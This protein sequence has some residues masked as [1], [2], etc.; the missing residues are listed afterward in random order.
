MIALIFLS[1]CNEDTSHSKTDNPDILQSTIPLNSNGQLPEMFESVNLLSIY[2]PAGNKDE[3]YFNLMSWQDYI[4][5]KFGLEINMFYSQEEVGGVSAVYYFNSRIKY[6]Y[7]RV[8]QVFNYVNP[9]MAY[10]L[11]PYYEKY[12]WDSL[13]ASEYIE[14]LKVDGSIYAIPTTPNKYIIPRYYNAEYLNQLDMEVPTDINSFRNYLVESKK[15][16]EGDGLLLPMFIPQRQMFPCM[17]DI[18][19][20]FGAYVNS[21]YNSTMSFNP[22]TQSF[23]DAVYSENIETALGFVKSLQEE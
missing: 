23:E 19:R 12:G 17:S 10:D 7:S 22:N 5:Q 1:G 21:E 20:A 15:I 13:I 14:A 4:F 2:Q 16:M 6:P 18:F 3:K 9:D 8:D 11:T